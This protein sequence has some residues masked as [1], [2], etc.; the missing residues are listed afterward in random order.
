MVTRSV[1]IAAIGCPRSEAPPGSPLETLSTQQLSR[2]TNSS[3]LGVP[4]ILKLEKKISCQKE[5]AG[6][7]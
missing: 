7:W 1:G 6:S 3:I 2:R 4:T 5:P